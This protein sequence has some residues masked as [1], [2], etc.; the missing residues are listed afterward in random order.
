[1]AF[2]YHYPEYGKYFA[3]MDISDKFANEA[4]KRIAITV[5]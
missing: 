1:V 5:S 3:S 4:K 2:L